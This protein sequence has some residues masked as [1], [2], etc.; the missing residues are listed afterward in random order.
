MSKRAS[1]SQ[2]DFALLDGRTLAVV[3]VQNGNRVIFRG[4]AALKRDVAL[5][6]VLVVAPQDCQPT[7][8][9]LVISLDEWTGSISRDV[10]Y[11]CDYCLMP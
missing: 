4:I 9:R 3:V 1:E 2:F 10:E 5:G 11:G 7:D 6:N 8:P